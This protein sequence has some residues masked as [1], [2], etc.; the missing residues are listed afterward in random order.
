MVKSYK[1][2]RFKASLFVRL[3]RASPLI[4]RQEQSTADQFRLTPRTEQQCDLLYDY[5]EAQAKYRLNISPHLALRPAPT[6]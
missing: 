6:S 2:R 3:D 4:L 5:N 1:E